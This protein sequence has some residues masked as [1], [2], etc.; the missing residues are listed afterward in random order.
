MPGT[1]RV[2]HE[3]IHRTY[4]AGHY[5]NWRVWAGALS[6]DIDGRRYDAA[7]ARAFL[8]DGPAPRARAR[9]EL[10]V[11][12]VDVARV[13]TGD[14]E[15]RL[16][17]DA[18]DAG[19]TYLPM[20]LQ[21][22]A[23]GTPVPC[24]NNLVFE[25]APFALQCTG[26]FSCIVELSATDTPGTTWVPINDMAEN[27]DGVIVVSP[28]WV[29]AAPSMTEVCLRKVDAETRDGRF[30]SGRI[31]NLTRRLAELPTDVVYLLPFY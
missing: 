18:I 8:T 23:D 12:D 24:G 2:L 7:L 28:G 9:C 11:A 15:A 3:Q 20:H 1:C 19:G 27:R 6:I 29:A 25:S 26:A 13:R 21:V 5:D 17:T 16:W 4:A 14:V 22:A 30:A 10:F 31:A